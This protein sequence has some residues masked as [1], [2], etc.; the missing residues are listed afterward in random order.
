MF[1]FSNAQ[2]GA[3]GPE[4][5][6]LQRRIEALKKTL[7]GS[8]ENMRPFAEAGHTE[9]CEAV[10][11]RLK[12][13][14]QDP[15]LPQDFKRDTFSRMDQLVCESF[16]RAADMAVHDAQR[17]AMRDDREVRDKKI[18]E[19]RDKMNFD[20]VLVGFAALRIL[21]KPSLGFYGA[22]RRL[23]ETSTR[24]LALGTTLAVALIGF[25]AG[26]L[27]GGLPA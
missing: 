24:R 19:A 21:A 7:T 23:E 8:V 13:L 26:V 4:Q 25:A 17:A 5:E 2:R 6:A 22:T 9:K 27:P 18:I 11:E 14:L 20:G 15:I 10:V 12:K 1:G 16:M 3:Q